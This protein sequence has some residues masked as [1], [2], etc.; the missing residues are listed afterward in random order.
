VAVCAVLVYNYF[1]SRV[2]EMQVDSSESAL[3]IVDLLLKHYPELGSYD[4]KPAA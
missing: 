4:P 3:E 2:E 1:T